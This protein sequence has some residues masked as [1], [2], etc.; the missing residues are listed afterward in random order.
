MSEELIFNKI[1]HR[2]AVDEY[3]ILDVLCQP[4][5]K[6]E[7]FRGIALDEIITVENHP[8]KS[9]YLHFEYPHFNGKI[10]HGWFIETLL[11]E[12]ILNYLRIYFLDSQIKKYL[13]NV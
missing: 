13:Q 6:W 9:Y 11:D 8:E 7:Y 5:L 3:K 1:N 10:K 4:I 12:K 2:Q